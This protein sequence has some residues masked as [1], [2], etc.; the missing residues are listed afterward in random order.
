MALAIVVVCVS[1]M[2][3][4]KKDAL[5]ELEH[6]DF[7]TKATPQSTKPWYGKEIVFDNDQSFISEYG[8]DGCEVIEITDS[9]VIGEKPEFILS[10][11]VI[12]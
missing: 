12:R 10:R 8:K 1:C 3:A 7:P 4:P 11:M 9:V 6:T 5:F 2:P